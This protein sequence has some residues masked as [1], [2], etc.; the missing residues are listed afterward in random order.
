MFTN[1]DFQ[2]EQFNGNIKDINEI[3]YQFIK[4]HHNP[5]HTAGST[6]FEFPELGIIFTG[7]F[8][9][10]ESIGRTDLK[11]GNHAAMINSIKNVFTNFNPD[12]EILPGH[13]ESEK[14]SIISKDNIFI[15]EHVND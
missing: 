1:N 15:K 9:F 8:V 4:S 10:K 13:G 7:D 2:A 6:S 5:G 12:Y 11:S 14:V 3:P